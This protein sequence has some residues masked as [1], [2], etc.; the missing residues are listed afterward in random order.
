MM[1]ALAANGS[2][3]PAVAVGRLLGDAYG[4]SAPKS[5]FAADLMTVSPKL[6]PQFKE[7]F[8]S[9]GAPF[10]FLTDDPAGLMRSHNWDAMELGYDEV[11][12]RVGTE[13]VVNGCV[14]IGRRP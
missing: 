8:A 11:A 12:R 3:L 13:V 6:R 10:L 7:L 5:C 2:P 9:L 14:V 4:L 1:G